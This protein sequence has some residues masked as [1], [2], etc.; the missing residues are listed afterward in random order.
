MDSCVLDTTK[1]VKKGKEWLCIS[2]IKFDIS[3]T[4]K[5]TLNGEALGNISLERENT[6]CNAQVKYSLGIWCQLLP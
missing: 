2:V 1:V 4:E 3:K 6:Q 5:K